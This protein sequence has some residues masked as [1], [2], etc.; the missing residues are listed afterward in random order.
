M[1]PRF[2]VIDEPRRTEDGFLDAVRQATPDLDCEQMSWAD[3]TAP[4]LAAARARLLVI[5]AASRDLAPAARERSWPRLPADIPRLILLDEAADGE[6]IRQAMELADDFALA[7]WRGGELRQRILRLI[8]AVTPTGR[9]DDQTEAARTRLLQ[10]IALSGL[11]GQ[12]PRFLDA[13]GKIPL[14]ARDE[15]GPVLIV[16]ETGT[17]KELCARAIHN[18]GPRKDFPYIPVDCATLPD[19]LFENEIFGHASGAFTDARKDQKGLVALAEGGTLFLDEIDSLSIS[20]QSKLLRLLQ[21]RSYRPL[22]SARFLA[23]DIKIVAA[24]NCDLEA[25]VQARTFRAD[26][27][28]RLNVLRLD[29]PPLRRRRSDIPL[30]AR[31]ILASVCEECRIRAK[32]LTPAALQALSARDWPGNVR[33]LHNALKRAALL[34]ENSAL[35]PS[36]LFAAAESDD[37]AG[38]RGFQAARQRAIESF[39]QQYVL[40]LMRECGGNVSRAARL[41]EKERRAFGRLVKRYAIPRDF[42]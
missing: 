13:I 35:T 18:V 25:L 40:K 22:G 10:Q 4:R 3:A 29:L 37:D 24:S 42:P 2:V 9:G 41:A 28:F 15:R 26:L 8:G 14:F 21:E 33:E 16:G 34:S 38:A 11:V 1:K 19:H 23:C 27:Y 32:T 12:D 20:A 17:G 36:D 7:P 30:L 31:H 39:E 6:A 5:P